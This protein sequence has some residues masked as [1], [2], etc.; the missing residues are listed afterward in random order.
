VNCVVE[1]V[2]DLQHVI[3]P[4]QCNFF[5]GYTLQ[6]TL[7]S[8]QAVAFPLFFPLFKFFFPISLCV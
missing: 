3:L 7:S 6:L 1:H 4:F 5:F 2:Q 8:V